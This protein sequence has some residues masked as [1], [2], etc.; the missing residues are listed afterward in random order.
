MHRGCAILLNT[1]VTHASHNCF[2]YN[3]DMCGYFM[4]RLFR[5]CMPL[6]RLNIYTDTIGQVERN[7]TIDK[8]YKTIIHQCAYSLIHGYDIHFLRDAT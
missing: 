5:L 4:G 7:I 3:V 8:A 6:L 2:S 1:F